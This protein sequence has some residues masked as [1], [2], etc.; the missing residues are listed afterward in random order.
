MGILLRSGR[1]HPVIVSSPDEEIQRA[2]QDRQ[3]G[4]YEAYGRVVQALIKHGRIKPGLGER[5]ATDL[6]YG[7]LS[8]ELHSLLCTQRGWP[9]G[10]FKSWVV[11]TLEDQLLSDQ[12]PP[13]PGWPATV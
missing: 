4:R 7:L 12:A 3:D 9:P 11:A 10:Q 6:M 8:P 1:L 2:F 13:V 5:K